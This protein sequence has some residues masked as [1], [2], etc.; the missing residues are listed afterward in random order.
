LLESLEIWTDFFTNAYPV[1]DFL[2]APGVPHTVLHKK[3]SAPGCA[4]DLKPDHSS[5]GRSTL[6]EFNVKKTDTGFGSSPT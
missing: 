2:G 5:R 6:G 4:I 1:G 3:G